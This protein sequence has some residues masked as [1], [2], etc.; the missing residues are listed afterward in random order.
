[1]LWDTK[2]ETIVNNESSEIIRMMYTEFDDW[3]SPELQEA[4]RPGGGFY[5][6]ALRRDIDEMNEW[7]YHSINNGVYKAGF[8]TTQA[9]YDKHV[10][11]LFAALDRVEERLRTR[12]QKYLVGDYITEADIRLYPTIARFDVA[13]YLIFKCNLK[14]IR[15]DYPHLDRWFRSL[16]WDESAE[17]NGGA[18]KKTT[19]F[20]LVGVF[21]LSFFFFLHS[22]LKFCRTRASPSIT[23]MGAEK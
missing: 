17:T 7:V 10:Y 4:N 6:P 13:Y 19:F 21:G 11:P 1:V 14:M 8:A 12:G 18:F 16:Y 20:D 3:L 15:H 9:A 2:T 5:P 23:Q 22:A